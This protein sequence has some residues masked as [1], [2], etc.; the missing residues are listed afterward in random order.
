MMD[1]DDLLQ[2]FKAQPKELNVAL[3]ITDHA[4]LRYS[5]IWKQVLVGRISDHPADESWPALW[6]CVRIDYEAISMLADDEMVLTRKTV[7]RLKGL[8]LIYPDGTL[9]ELAERAIEKKLKQW[10]S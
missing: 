4:L 1:F 2:C 6:D 7:E 10:M 9:P 5:V 8:Q 3:L